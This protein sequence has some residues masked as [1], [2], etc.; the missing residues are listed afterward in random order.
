MLFR[1]HALR[2]IPI[3]PS[4][5]TQKYCQSFSK[6]TQEH[7]ILRH[8]ERKYGKHVQFAPYINGLW[9]RDIGFY[10]IDV[11]KPK[12]KYS[13]RTMRTIENKQ[14]ANQEKKGKSNLK[15]Y[16]RFEICEF[17]K[18]YQLKSDDVILLK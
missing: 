4:R 6:P 9:V 16:L 18:K 2:C 11:I 7:N 12:L 15:R 5:S 10:I 3:T 17:D 13:S 8:I 14:R 1:S